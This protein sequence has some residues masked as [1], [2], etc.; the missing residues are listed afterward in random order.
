MTHRAG[1]GWG[2]P[3]VSSWVGLLRGRDG[4]TFRAGGPTNPDPAV[5][6]STAPKGEL[7]RPLGHGSSLSPGHTA[8]RHAW[9][10]QEA[11]ADC[12]RWASR[13]GGAPAVRMTLLAKVAAVAEVA[14][15]AVQTGHAPLVYPA[16]AASGSAAVGVRFLPVLP[17]VC[18]RV[19][20]TLV[21]D[22]VARRGG[23]IGVLL[24]GVPIGAWGADPA[25]RGSAPVTRQL[26]APGTARR[27]A[28]GPGRP[29]GAARPSADARPSAL[30]RLPA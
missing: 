24:T 27:P 11:P 5:E 3:P 6:I 13:P 12:G 28:R 14:G 16:R 18:A 21:G 9:T 29:D 2:C 30:T 7:P 8:W 25:E 20:D 17:V 15:L 19:G 26:L 4:V 1:P 10:L 22:G 23:A